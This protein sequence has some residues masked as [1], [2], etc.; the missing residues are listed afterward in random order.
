VKPDYLERRVKHNE[1]VKINWTEVSKT[2]LEADANLKFFGIGTKGAVSF[3]HEKAKEAKL[4][5]TNFFI[6]EGP[7]IDMLNHD[8][9]GARNFLAKEGNDGRIVS[10]VWV[11]VTAELGEQFAANGET[12]LSVQASGNSL[13]VTV[14]GGRSG[15]ETI[16]LSPDSTFAYRLHKVTDWT[17]G[18]THIKGMTPDYKGIA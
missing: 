14:K 17:D 6:N 15:S 9:E 5:L 2:D 18:K 10:E 3:N 8:A 16:T 13:N 4:E 11:V 7:L 1:R 12:S